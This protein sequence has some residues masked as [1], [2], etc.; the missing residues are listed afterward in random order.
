MTKKPIKLSD[1]FCLDEMTKTSTGINNTPGEKI[2]ERLKNTAAG[3]EKVCA[4][5]DNKLIIVKSGYRSPGVNKAVGGSKTSDHMNGDACDFDCPA[6]GTDFEVADA[7]RKSDIKF[8]QLI[9]EYGWVHISFGPRMRQ[10]CL[11]KR[12]AKAPYEL[13]IN[14]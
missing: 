8:D 4:L 7:I 5:L 1:H 2:L 13:G 6:F 10:Q 11:T 14:K 3:M 9:L 12:S